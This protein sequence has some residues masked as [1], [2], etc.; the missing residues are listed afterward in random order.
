MYAVLLL[1]GL[2]TLLMAGII[3]FVQIVHYPL[4]AMVDA[5][6]FPAYERRHQHLTT[7]VVGP[8]MIVEMATGV[9]LLWTRP[10]GVPWTLA[11]AGVVLLAIIWISTWQ[12]QVPQHRA[13]A[14]AF[15]AEVQ[16]NLVRHN[17]WRTIAWSLRTAVVLA[18]LWYALPTGS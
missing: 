1:H 4:F 8:L 3:W 13:L 9:L 2:T 11:A 12:V 16:R 17:W 14:R 5:P 7:C 15:T 6:S 10:A 18:M